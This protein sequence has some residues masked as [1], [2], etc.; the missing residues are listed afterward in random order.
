MGDVLGELLNQFEDDVLDDVSQ[1]FLAQFGER[2][3]IV[4][5]LAV[6]LCAG[7]QFEGDLLLGGLAVDGHVE[8]GFWRVWL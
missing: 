6:W 8:V 2:V 1:A 5:L 4:G 7:G 3:E